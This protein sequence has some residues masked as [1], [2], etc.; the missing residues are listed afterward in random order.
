[1]QHQ[2]GGLSLALTL[3]VKVEGADMS[4]VQQMLGPICR[5]I[6][7]ELKL[8][9]LLERKNMLGAVDEVAQDH[10]EGVVAASH[11]FTLV[12]GIGQSAEVDRIK[13]DQA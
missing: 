3:L 8:F 5:A 4:E 11:C 12:V 2:R 9:G 13:V 1:L 7:V 10:F 6:Q